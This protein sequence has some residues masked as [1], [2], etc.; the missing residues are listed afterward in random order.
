MT[1]AG[2]HH[3]GEGEKH[4]C[5]K[6]ADDDAEECSMSHEVLLMYFCL[7]VG[8]RTI[9]EMN[10]GARER[11]PLLLSAALRTKRVLYVFR[12]R[13]MVGRSNRTPAS[14]IFAKQRDAR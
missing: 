1:H 11:A 6:A 2:S 12:P 8:Q 13:L 10:K 14:L 3:K 9:S 5:D 7:P 4:S